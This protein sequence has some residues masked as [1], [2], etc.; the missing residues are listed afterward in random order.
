MKNVTDPPGAPYLG[1][2]EGSKTGLGAANLESRRVPS[3][4]QGHLIRVNG[5][6]THGQRA[7]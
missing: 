3:K 5:V 4:D 2:K 7:P 1:V 6:Q